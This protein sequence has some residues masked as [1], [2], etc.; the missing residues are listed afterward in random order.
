MIGN[1]KELRNQIVL[2]KQKKI[3]N[4]YTKAMFGRKKTKSLKE[5]KKPTCDT[6]FTINEVLFNNFNGFSYSLGYS[7]LE[8]V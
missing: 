3:G 8:V 4:Y 5:N 6:D 1:V 2:E 7:L